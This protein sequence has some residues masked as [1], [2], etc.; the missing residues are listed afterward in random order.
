MSQYVDG[1][2]T[3]L[4]I[5]GDQRDRKRTMEFT[6]DPK[7]ASSRNGFVARLWA[8][9]KIG[10]LIEQIR[11]AGADRGAADDPKVKELIDE[12]VHLSM[13]FG[14]M[15]EYTAFL[16]DEKDQRRGSFALDRADF[17]FRAR[18][19]DERAGRGA[20][21][22]RMNS[23]ILE[24]SPALARVGQR[25]VVASDDS[26]GVELR[27]IDTIKQVK[28]QALY[29]KGDR[30]IDGR[31]LALEAAEPDETIEFATERYFELVAQLAKE[32]RQALLADKGDIELLLDGKRVLIRNRG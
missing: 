24:A 8:S 20:V 11:L 27:L 14:I 13:D 16:A 4:V 25:L 30:W 9:R 29:K 31:L 7:N 17:N 1:V 12:V 28:E 22:Q 15:T 26:E 5:E 21:T 10:S 23:M 2:R 18:A 6:F 19:L 3:V 32:G